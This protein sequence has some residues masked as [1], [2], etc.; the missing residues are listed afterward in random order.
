MKPIAQ[1]CVSAA[2]IKEVTKWFKRFT[3]WCKKYEIKTEDILNFDEVGFQIGVAFNEDII[4]LAY[5]KEVS[6]ILIF[7]ILILI[8]YNY[9]LQL[10]KTRNQSQCLK[11]SLQIIQQFL[12]L[13]LFKDDN[14]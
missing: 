9:I 10:L 8:Y 13:L 3:K 5:V 1:V 7:N 11:L 2:D 14:I 4:I 6:I 12:Q